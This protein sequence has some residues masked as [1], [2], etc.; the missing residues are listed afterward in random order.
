MDNG[1]KKAENK[2]PYTAE[3]AETV[4]VRKVQRRNVDLL[5]LWPGMWYTTCD[6]TA[7]LAMKTPRDIIH[8][9]VNAVLL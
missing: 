5:P 7:V 4:Q 3:R 9:Y 6:F 8:L 2:R 1:S